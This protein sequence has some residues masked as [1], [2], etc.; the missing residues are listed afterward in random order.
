[1]VWVYD[2]SGGSL[3]V[4]MLMHV[5]L[6]ASTFILG[7]LVTGMALLTY[8]LALAAAWWVVVGAVAVVGGWHIARQPLRRRVA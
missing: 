8:S 3:L 2:R 4:A 7:T 6:A 5:S 1:M